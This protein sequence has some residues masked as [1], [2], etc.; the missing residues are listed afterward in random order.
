MKLKRINET[1]KEASCYFLTT[2]LESS[3]EIGQKDNWL[4]TLLPCFLLWSMP[5]PSGMA[6]CGGAPESKRRKHAR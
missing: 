5:L 1:H 4:F 6:K 3:I 2:R